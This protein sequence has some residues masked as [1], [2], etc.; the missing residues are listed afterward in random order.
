MPA[1]VAGGRRIEIV[2]SVL[3]ADFARLGEA[4]TALGEA[5]VDRIQW[6]VMD[7]QFVPNIT[8][9]PDVIAACRPLV[10]MPFEAH[11][12][13]L[14]PEPMLARWVQAGCEIVI[15][16]AEACRHLHRT[17]AT[18]RD[19]GARAGVALNPATPVDHVA[20]IL[21]LVDLVLVMTINPGFGGQAYL[22]SM[23]PKIAAV[24]A[25]VAERG[26]DVDIEVDGGI[27]PDTVGGATSAGA[28]LLVAGS[29][30]FRDERGLTAA[31]ADLRARANAGADAA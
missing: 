3:P 14:E 17:L 5:G 29:A 16:H 27:A 23:E 24:A 12:M 31:V 2:P 8:V 10:D 26:L 22:P 30:L 20:H 6:D 7:G 13:V 4:C 21:D 25:L 19:L 15:V 9:G 11:L 28:N 18:I 1:T